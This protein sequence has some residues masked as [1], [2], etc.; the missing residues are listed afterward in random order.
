MRQAESIVWPGGEHDFRLGIGELRALEQKSDAG[1][2]VILMRLL[3]AAWKIDDV[4]GPIRLGL[5]GGGMASHE[6]Q[7]AVDEA[8]QEVSPYALAVT[9]ADVLRRFIMWDGDDQPGEADAGAGKQT[10]TRSPTAEPDGQATTAPVA[11]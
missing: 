2:A 11:P 3:G 4:I 8:L 9:A 6:A 1:C 5:I 7:K 10:Q